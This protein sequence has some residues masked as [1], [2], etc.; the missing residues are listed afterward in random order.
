MIIIEVAQQTEL[1]GAQMKMSLNHFLQLV[2]L[3]LDEE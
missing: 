2:D 3:Y 1:T